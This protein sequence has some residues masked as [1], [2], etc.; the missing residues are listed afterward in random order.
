MIIDPELKIWVIK[1]YRKIRPK[2]LLT[3]NL[4][5]KFK[6]YEEYIK[7][8]IVFFKDDADN[9]L[10]VQLSITEIIFF[11]IKFLT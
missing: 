3:L 2:T 5:E 1:I 8:K 6:K 11:S 7:V 10:K 9:N 4:E